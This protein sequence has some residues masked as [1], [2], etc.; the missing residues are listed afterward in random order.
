MRK[1]HKSFS[2]L[3]VILIVSYALGSRF[4]KNT[5]FDDVLHSVYYKKYKLFQTLR[6]IKLSCSVILLSVGFC[7]LRV[8]S[9]VESICQPLP[10][11]V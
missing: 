2:F 6:H 7:I 4:F 3:K 10:E 9:A 8:D 1:M 11:L 5:L